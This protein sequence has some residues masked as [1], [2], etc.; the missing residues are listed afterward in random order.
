[1]VMVLTYRPV[2]PKILYISTNNRSGKR[3]RFILGFKVVNDNTLTLTHDN[4]MEKSTG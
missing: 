2:K 4:F 3:N 1:M